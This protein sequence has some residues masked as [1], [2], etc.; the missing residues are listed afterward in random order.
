MLVRRVALA[1]CVSLPPTVLALGS[2]LGLVVLHRSRARLNIQPG[3]ATGQVSLPPSALSR[4]LTANRQ[5]KSV[6][7]GRISHPE[8]PRAQCHSHLLPGLGLLRSRASTELQLL[9]ATRT[10]AVSLPPSGSS[11][12]YNGCHM[13]HS[14]IGPV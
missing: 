9:P 10:R 14:G 3:L 13:S 8:W 5:I 12:A 2:W 6:V 1:Q 11:K 7:S 4:P